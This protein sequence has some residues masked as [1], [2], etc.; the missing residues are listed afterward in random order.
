MCLVFAGIRIH[1][2]LVA[3]DTDGF[4]LLGYYNPKPDFING[5]R[6]DC[7]DFYKIITTAAKAQ[8]ITIEIIDSKH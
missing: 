3:V 7:K 5:S 2:G 6:A 8:K 1:S 4:V